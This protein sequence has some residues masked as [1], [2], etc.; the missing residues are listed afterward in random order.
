MVKRKIEDYKLNQHMQ[1]YIDVDM[2][3]VQQN[4]DNVLSKISAIDNLFKS[5]ME[6]M[7]VNFVRRDP[8]RAYYNY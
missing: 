7:Y 6:M 2:G 5:K 4:Y 8:F 1:D 3:I